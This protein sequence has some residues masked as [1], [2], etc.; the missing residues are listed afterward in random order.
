MKTILFVED[1]PEVKL[2]MLICWLNAK[3]IRFDYK[4]VGSIKDAKCYLHNGYNKVDIVITDLGLPLFSGYPVRDL[5][6][7]M[8]IVCDMGRLNQK[9]PVIIN[10]ATFIPNFEN[11]KEAYDLRG[12]QLYKVDYIM[13][14]KD[15]LADFLTN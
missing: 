6:Q 4:I 8:D 2:S 10:S 15:W 14:I 12:Q 11:I 13:D 9:V 5:L 7:G 1:F 3:G